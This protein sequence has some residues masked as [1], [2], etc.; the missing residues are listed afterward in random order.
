MVN[1]FLVEFMNGA[2]SATV[3]QYHYGLFNVVCKNNGINDQIVQFTT[4]EDAEK[5]AI[6]YTGKCKPNLLN[7]N[8]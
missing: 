5:Y 4:Q 1:K 2:K 6:Y 3:E 7:E 8:V